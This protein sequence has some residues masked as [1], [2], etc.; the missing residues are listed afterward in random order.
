MRTPR[1]RARISSLSVASPGACSVARITPVHERSRNSG[2][3]DTLPSGPGVFTARDPASP[4]PSSRKQ[5]WPRPLLPLTSRQRQLA[6]GPYP[7]TSHR[8]P[9]MRLCI[10]VARILR[11]VIA[12]TRNMAVPTGSTPRQ[13]SAF[14]STGLMT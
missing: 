7:S 8:Q 9:R 12:H 4:L 13:Y 5:S 3:A 6:R 11:Q 1:N 14:P 10:E 2:R